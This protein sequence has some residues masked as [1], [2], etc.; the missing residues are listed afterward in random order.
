MRE[1]VN[2]NREGTSI[3]MVT[4]SVRVAAMSD[5]VLYLMDGDIQGEIE[6]GKL[7]DEGSITGRERLLSNWLMERG[8]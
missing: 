2:A 3:M 4:H 6:L 5:K 8:W 1:L 7:T